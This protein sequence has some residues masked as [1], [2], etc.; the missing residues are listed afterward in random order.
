MKADVAQ[1]GME[2]MKESRRVVGVI[3]DSLTGSLWTVVSRVTGLGQSVAVA[4]ILGA[5]YLG[6]TYQAINSLP[7]IIYYQLLAGSL[8]ASILVP[9]LVARR[10]RGD[11]AGTEALAQGFYGTLL[12]GAAGFCLLLI[13]AGPAILHAFTLGVAD[14]TTAALQRRV[15]LVFLVI[16]VPQIA[17]YVTA[18]TGAA[19]MNAHGRFALA[20]GA[21]ALENVGMI[22][23]LILVGVLFGTGTSL[24]NVTTPQVLLLGIGTT[25][26]V[27][28][29]A[30]AQWLGARSCNVRLRP[31][32]G[33][34]DPEV[35]RVLR[36]VVPTLAFTGLA[37]SQTVVVL[38][39]ANRIAGGLVAFQLAL[40]FFFLPIA[41]VAWPIARSMLPHLAR[42]TSVDDGPAFWDELCRAV[43]LASFVTAP[44]AVAYVVLATPIARAIAIGQLEADG[45]GP[46]VA[47]SLGALGLGVIG[48]TWFILGTYAFYA[49]QDVRAPLRSMVIR[50][51]VVASVLSF[52]LITHRPVL[53]LVLGLAMSA[54]SVIGSV[55]LWARLRAS[56]GGTLPVRPLARTAAAACITAVPA[57]L[58]AAGLS[59]WIGAHELGQIAVVVGATMTGAGAYLLSQRALGAPE[60]GLLRLGTT[61][62]IRHGR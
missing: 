27:G 17:L 9:P 15:G 31:R 25:A 49:R 47:M 45:G 54:G 5:T 30:C 33:W 55:H 59:R 52:A 1:S 13:L 6:N 16:F 39:L 8:F 21:P 22:S 24:A 34:R 61:S 38:V 53:L 62:L 56:S 14:P 40:N 41:V 58:T 12:T 36:R 18:G 23:T 3:R 20:A 4:T 42:L 48:E 37:A 57:A 51:V 32:A 10:D 28:V 11:A 46:L 7:N 26:S 50:V 43:R 2:S 29:H 35:R 19:V 44:M 60:L